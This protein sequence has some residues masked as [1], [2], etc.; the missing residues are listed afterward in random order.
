MKK[1]RKTSVKIL[2]ALISVLMLMSSVS[3]TS[4]AY[5]LTGGSSYPFYNYRMI[6]NFDNIATTSIPKF[7]TQGW[8]HNDTFK[9][10]TS[11]KFEI[12]DEKLHFFNSGS[13][14]NMGQ[15]FWRIGR[16]ADN[17]D[18]PLDRGL[19]EFGFDFKIVGED[20]T[21]DNVESV[22]LVTFGGQ[23]VVCA[24]GSSLYTGRDKETSTLLTDNLK[25][26]QWYSV[27]LGMNMD[28]GKTEYMYF[29]GDY[30]ED[31]KTT[32]LSV[33]YK[34]VSKATY[35]GL[36][37]HFKN[38]AKDTDIYFD[39]MYITQHTAE[40]VSSSVTDGETGVIPGAPISLEFSEDITEES[41]QGITLSK[42]GVL[43]EGTSVSVSDTT[44]VISHPLLAD[45]SQYVITIPDTVCSDFISKKEEST[46]TFTTGRGPKTYYN[47]DFE[48]ITEAQNAT[49]GTLMQTLTKKTGLSWQYGLNGGVFRI[50]DASKDTMD[51]ARWNQDPSMP[52]ILDGTDSFVK[53]ID[54]KLVMQNSNKFPEGITSPDRRYMRFVLP[55]EVTSGIVKVKLDYESPIHTHI[56]S[57]TGFMQELVSC[58]DLQ[59]LGYHNKKITYWDAEKTVTNDKWNSTCLK[60]NNANTLFEGEQ[61][62]FDITLDLDNNIS[63]VIFDGKVHKNLPINPNGKLNQ[64]MMYTTTIFDEQSPKNYYTNTV[65]IDNVQIEIYDSPAV[66]NKEI[67]DASVK[68]GFTLEFN[69]KMAEVTGITM[70]DEAGNNVE[71]VGTL[72]PDGYRYT[73]NPVNDLLV[74]SNYTVT[75]PAQTT[76]EEFTMAA[77]TVKVFTELGRDNLYLDSYK[78]AGDL[79]ANAT[80]S[81]EAVFG[82]G[83]EQLQKPWI[84]IALY[85]ANHKLLNI[86]AGTD[87]FKAGAL[88]SVMANLTVP[89]D[90]SEG[91]YVKIFAWE[92]ISGIKP[93]VEKI[94]YPEEK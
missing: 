52:F 7:K 11:S 73:I 86:A 44:V 23:T 39:N 45:F 78:I 37:P 20:F 46:I 81:V 18:K 64:I 63:T 28:A 47:V 38:A 14:S 10:L 49:T 69:T 58:G 84:G 19:V 62:K 27:V 88:K 71:F 61:H 91:V 93:L 16:F 79:I 24:Y 35:F 42:D 53:V 54:G 56:G 82:N 55:K 89:S 17:V 41:A 25:S 87:D 32:N 40:I 22:A 94:V 76:A 57:L 92:N 13:E 60:Y 21:A 26:G 51:G 43:V 31:V 74:A 15:L 50:G 4:F 48:N 72:L 68:D 6:E 65:K 83:S 12:A 75:I 77:Q 1:T 90:V 2:A 9:S 36:S 5:T 70:A 29:N 59:Q 3:L 66:V 33:L 8:Y 85:D 30:V 80:F 34:D 67:L